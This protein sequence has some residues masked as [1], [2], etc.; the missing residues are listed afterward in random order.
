MSTWCGTHANV[1]VCNVRAYATQSVVEHVFMAIL[2]LQRRLVEHLAAVNRGVDTRQR[3][4]MLDFRSA[5]W[6]ARPWESSVMANSARRL[7]TW[8]IPLA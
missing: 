8:A 4:S 7:R 2:A 3:F 5:N 1:A 6:R